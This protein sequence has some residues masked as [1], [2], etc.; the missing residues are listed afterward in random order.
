VLLPCSDPAV[1]ES[2]P[3]RHGHRVGPH[4]PDPVR[5]IV[6]AGRVWCRVQPT[7][8]RPI[9]VINKGWRWA[10]WSVGGIML[11][12]S[13]CEGEAVVATEPG[14]PER[15]ET[16]PPDTSLELRASDDERHRVVELLGE[17]A[18]AGRITL[19]E[20]EER[21]GQAYGATTRGELAELIRDLPAL[22][23]PDASPSLFESASASASASPN[24]KHTR[25]YFAIMG[26]STRRG[27]RFAE[28]LNVVAVMGGDDIDLRDAEIESSELVVNVFS[29]MGGAA[30]YL[31]DNV[32][33]ELSG[34]AI[35]GGNDERGSTRPPRPGAP[36]VRIR[37]F[38]LMGGVDVWR[39]PW[40]ARHLRLK[41]A[42]R[43]AKALE[44]GDHQIEG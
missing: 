19:S 6:D 13:E 22:P 26:G 7:L 44:R 37:S 33:V 27:K 9:A 40:A 43:V 32:E 3:S 21:V 2:S 24:R 31:S 17:H 4:W 16:N 10:D 18:A 20:L 8:S 14:V 30:I 42:R 35:M 41:E 15:S 38:A 1:V 25:W 29:L 39:V 34:G 36:I 23:A 5:S 12:R 11:G 28:Q